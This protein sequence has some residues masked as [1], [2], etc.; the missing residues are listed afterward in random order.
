MNTE[1]ERLAIEA[2][3]RIAAQGHWDNVTVSPEIFG[4]LAATIADLQQQLTE[5]NR[6]GEELVHM[7]R[8]CRALIPKQGLR[9]EIDELLATATSKRGV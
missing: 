1:R 9:S 7:V 6:R 3:I 4:T 8:R 2:A 5:A